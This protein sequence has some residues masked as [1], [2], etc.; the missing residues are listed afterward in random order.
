MGCRSLKKGAMACEQIMAKE[1]CG[2][3]EL[4]DEQRDV[5]QIARIRRGRRERRHRGSARGATIN[6]GAKIV[7]NE[8][9]QQV[10]NRSAEMNVLRIQVQ[11][12]WAGELANEA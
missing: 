11:F 2:R 8:I 5:P 9:R 12:F 1:N 6:C 7:Q 10:P 3:L 4:I